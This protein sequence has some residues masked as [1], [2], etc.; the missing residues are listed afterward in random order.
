MRLVLARAVSRASVG[1][2][3]RDE[4]VELG[5]DAR[6]ARE[7]AALEHVRRGL[8]LAAGRCN[9]LASERFVSAEGV[10]CTGAEGPKG[11]EAASWAARGGGGGG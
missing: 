7:E 9:P 11:Q 10:A 5:D 3:L 8:G 2:V 6:R 1:K 4:L